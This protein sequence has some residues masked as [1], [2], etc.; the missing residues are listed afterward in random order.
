MK[1]RTKSLMAVLAAMVLVVSACSS[2]GDEGSGADTSGVPS[3]AAGSATTE[4]STTTAGPETTDESTTTEAGRPDYTAAFASIEAPAAT[5]TV[6]G[7]GSDWDGIDGISLVLEPIP[8]E[9]EGGDEEPAPEGDAGAEV[10]IENKD[11]VV[12]M[13][14][15]DENAYLL[16]TIEDDLNW[17]SED[18][19]L[20]GAAAVL[21]AIKDSPGSA[22]GATPE[23]HENSLGLVDIWHFELGCATGV[24][25]GGAVSG[26]GDGTGGN[27]DGCNLDDEYATGPE[28]RED[29][30]SATAENSL[31]GQWTHTASVQDEDGTWTFEL[32]RPL[33]TGDSQ[34]VQFAVG[35]S[36]LMGV[37]YWDA[38]NTPEGW[39]DDQHVTSGNSGFVEVTLVG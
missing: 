13:A 12:K 6:D 3:T 17:D 36:V 37:A 24:A 18:S 11:A 8:A 29:D 22:M 2:G 16:L 1:K 26:P 19:N 28:D 39:D 5:I 9:E 23:N 33:V 20:S 4:E 14:H 31:L 32:S 25:S 15:D 35:E 27:D 38:D 30:D 10:V 34:D 21:F 7:D